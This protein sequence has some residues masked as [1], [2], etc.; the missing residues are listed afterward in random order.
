MPSTKL[1]LEFICE[2]R[3]EISTRTEDLKFLTQ[4]YLNLNFIYVF[5][6]LCITNASYVCNTKANRLVF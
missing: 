6:S 1:E 4:I 2:A 5:M 3:F